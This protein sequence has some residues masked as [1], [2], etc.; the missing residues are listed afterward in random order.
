MIEKRL[1]LFSTLNWN[2]T[3]FYS[4]CTPTTDN[5]CCVFPFVYHGKT[6]NSCT[7]VNRADNRL[8]CATTDSWD[9]DGK[10]GD[11]KTGRLESYICNRFISSQ[12]LVIEKFSNCLVPREL[13][14][15]VSESDRHAQTSDLR[16]LTSNTI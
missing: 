5:D 8:W 15:G 10:W 2:C 4:G 3:W 7:R 1:T 11:C 12:G 9:R 13:G 6:Y 16:P 14:G